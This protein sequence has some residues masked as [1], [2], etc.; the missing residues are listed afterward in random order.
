MQFFPIHSRSKNGYNIDPNNYGYKAYILYNIETTKYGYSCIMQKPDVI[1]P[2][3]HKRGKM[4]A[5]SAGRAKYLTAGF[6]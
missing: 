6:A 1:D 2:E 3:I 5:N 4:I